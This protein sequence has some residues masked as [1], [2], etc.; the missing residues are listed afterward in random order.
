MNSETKKIRKAKTK[1]PMGGVLVTGRGGANSIR[2]CLRGKNRVLMASKAIEKETGDD[3]L[4][5]NIV[6][7]FR[8]VKKDG[9][10]GV[11]L[12]LIADP[13]SEKSPDELMASAIKI[14]EYSWMKGMQFLV[15]QT[16]TNQ[17]PRPRTDD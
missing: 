5:Q 16:L 10:R 9:L 13:D 4:F 7:I 12:I 1:Y 17:C 11:L 8:D 3:Q 15:E 14:M 6:S 2:T